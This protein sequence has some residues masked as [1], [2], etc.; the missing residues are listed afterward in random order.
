MHI[1]FGFFELIV[2]DLGIDISMQQGVN[3]LAVYLI[4]D[5]IF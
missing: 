3:W 1:Q 4:T 2:E 5:F